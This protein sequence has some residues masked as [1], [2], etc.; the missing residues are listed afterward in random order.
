MAGKLI[1]VPTPISDDGMLEPIA[2]NLLKDAS[3]NLSENLIYIEDPKPARRRWI[4]W[5]LDREIIKD[6]TMF[7]EHT[8]KELIQKS[9]KELRSG[10]NI[11]LMSDGGLP[12][13]CDPGANLV[14]ACHQESITVT[15]T[16]FSNS[17][18]LAIALSGIDCRE[19]HF[20]GFPPKKSEQRVEFF[21]KVVNGECPSV[22]MDTPYRL[23]K[24][25]QEL[26]AARCKRKVFL[27]LDLC[28]SDEKLLFGSI[29]HIVK[30]LD[31]EKAEFILVIE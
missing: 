6:F 31:R 21:N 30:A 14:R 19:F 27:A 8:M 18:S 2:C 22:V 15:S 23:K 9:L 12:A 25:I 10:K 5:G 11:F 4:R 16:P 1:L 29:N 26:V 24:V 28:S 20:H 3:L 13:F 17:I 7:N